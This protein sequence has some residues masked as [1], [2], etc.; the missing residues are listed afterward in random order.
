MSAENK[1]V[2]SG[3]PRSALV[4]LL[5]VCLAAVGVVVYLV[6]RPADSRQELI[7]AMLE[8]ESPRAAGVNVLE[9]TD[10]LANP[11]AEAVE[12]QR[13]KVLVVDNARE[14]DS[15]IARIGGLV[16][17]VPGTQ[18]G[19]LVVVE[20][21]RLRRSTADSIVIERL[22]S[23]V[24]LPEQPSRAPAPVPR[25]EASPLV[26]QIFRGTIYD[27]AAEG[28]GVIRVSGKVVFVA[29]AVK[30]EHVEFQI[31]RDTDRFAHAVVLSKSPVPFAEDHLTPS[32]ELER[33]VQTTARR[34]RPV[35]SGQMMD[36]TVTETD[37]RN[38]SVDGVAR[39]DGFVIF[40]PGT[41][42]G[43]Q[44]RIRITDVRA[45]AASSEVISSN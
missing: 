3:I 31:T 44:V 17:F 35:T 36:V 7:I 5:F 30:G 4:A 11:A 29:G 14:G 28:D 13:Y 12:G 42:P 41:Q 43:D 26:G 20:V 15:G 38:P 16:T 23:G 10:T 40:V 1:Q 21:T 19:D 18:R 33:P 9:V 24:A 27:T 8:V 25:G 39:I 22:D 6:L 34:D 32:V 45:R 2:S 37:R